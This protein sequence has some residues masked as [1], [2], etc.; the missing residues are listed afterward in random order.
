MSL[1]N[2]FNTDENFWI[3]NPQFKNVQPFKN[4]HNSDK[5]RGKGK[6]SKIMWFVVQIADTSA[7]NVF[8][9]M[10]Y[11]EK[12]ALLSL[13]FMQDADY[14]DTNED[15]LQPLIDTYRRLHTTPALKAMEEWNEKMIERSEFIKNTSYSMDSYDMDERTGK[16]ILVKGTAK[17]LDDMMKNNKPIYDMYH[18]ILKSLAEEDENTQVKGGQHLSLSDTGEI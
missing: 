6:S 3:I 7:N 9:N 8:K 11:E 10:I 5:S 2:S 15:L 18:I 12:V 13:D 14:Y 17:Q 1:I 4:H 16:P